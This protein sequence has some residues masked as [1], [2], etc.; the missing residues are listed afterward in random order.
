M[1]PA[2]MDARAI[3]QGRLRSR[4]GKCLRRRVRYVTAITP[5]E[6]RRGSFRS[7][8]P[9]AISRCDS[10]PSAEAGRQRRSPRTAGRDG[11]AVRTPSMCSGRET[12]AEHREPARRFRLGRLILKNVPVL[13][14]LAVFEAHDI[15]GDP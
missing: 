13:G 7:H 5:R 12:I 4:G 9:H 2:R 8:E 15:G 1:M 11:S 10:Q 3:K 6:R 14:E